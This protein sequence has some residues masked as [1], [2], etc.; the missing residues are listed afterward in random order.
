MKET[1]IIL[2]FQTDFENYQTQCEEELTA[3]A[4]SFA[5]TDTH[6]DIEQVKVINTPKGWKSIHKSV[7][8]AGVVYLLLIL[9]V[10]GFSQLLHSPFM[11]C[12]YCKEK[13]MVPSEDF[14]KKPNL[15]S[16]TGWEYSGQLALDFLFKRS[17]QGHQYCS[18]GYAYA[19][20]IRTG[21]A[22]DATPRGGSKAMVNLI[23]SKGNKIF[24]K[25]AGEIWM[26]IPKKTL[27]D[28]YEWFAIDEV[29]NGYIVHAFE[30]LIQRNISLKSFKDMMRQTA[31]YYKTQ[32]NNYIKFSELRK[33]KGQRIKKRTKSGREIVLDETHEVAVTI[34]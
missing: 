27:D 1:K 34:W 33:Y 32:K 14:P 24:G 8:F 23:V 25:K 30:R 17:E 18:H 3:A 16:L 22:P 10:L 7:V 21:I 12:P 29:N 31:Q 5:F 11:E 28:F 20:P 13:V 2:D 4:L 6:E 15:D 19:S 9:P 26:R